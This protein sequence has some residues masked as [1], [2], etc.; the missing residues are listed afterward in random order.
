MP[1]TDL[2]HFIATTAIVDTHEHLRSQR[3]WV[4]DGPDVL[5]AILSHYLSGD[6]R[7]A[8]ASQEAMEFARDH[9]GR[10]VPQRVEA[11]RQAWQLTAHTG[12][13]Q[14][15][16][17]V[18]EQCFGIEQVEELAADAVL[19]AQDRLDVLRQPGQ[20]L[21]LLREVA[22][23]DH[24]Q[25][26]SGPFEPDEEDADFF[27]HDLSWVVFAAAGETMLQEAA[28]LSGVEIR[29]LA[30]LQRAM[31]AVFE[32]YGPMAIAVKTQHAYQRTLAWRPREDV[33]AA[34][35]VAKLLRGRRLDSGERNCL[36]DWCLAHGVRRAV[37]YN[38][39]IKIHCG[40]YAGHGTMRMER[41]QP[42]HLCELLIAF[43]QARFVLMHAG[44]PYVDEWIALG[45]HFPNAYLDL[46]WA[47]SIDPM[48]VSQAARKLV[49]AVPANKVFGFGGDTFWAT[50]VCAYAAQARFWL[51]R[52]LGTEVE[53][54]LLTEAQAIALAG[55]WL[56]GNQ[57]AC[58]DVERARAAIRQRP[59]AS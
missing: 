41:I 1:S 3:Q 48:T 19:A 13:G 44:Y 36:G 54:G 46:C 6:L 20:R 26:D 33:E 56:G 9:K 45:K 28:A 8:G 52:A 14:A 53:E 10:D 49:H 42:S 31:D 2:E 40:Y 25:I 7:N 16:R 58:F 21:R 35:A 18:A 34:D 50:T 59:P 30:S 23:L 57:R 15:A 5:Q 51:T 17:W 47:W 12:Y 27:L 29:N 32:R 24:V 43:P 39:P 37:E 38:L 11:I 4:E 22:K 55:R